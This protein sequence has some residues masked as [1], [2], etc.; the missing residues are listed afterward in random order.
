MAVM[1]EVSSF[2]VQLLFQLTM[3]LYCVLHKQSKCCL[4]EKPGP[5]PGARSLYKAH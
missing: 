4:M 5:H 3:K 1:L 2:R